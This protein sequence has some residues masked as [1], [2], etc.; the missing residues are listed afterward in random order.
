MVTTSEDNGRDHTFRTSTCQLSCFCLFQSITGVTRACV[1]RHYVPCQNSYAFVNLSEKNI[2]SRDDRRPSFSCSFSPII[3]QS[4]AAAAGTSSTSSDPAYHSRST[5]LLTDFW[6][7]LISQGATKDVWV[8]IRVHGA[9][10]FLR[11]SPGGAMTE[12]HRPS[13]RMM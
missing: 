7:A 1:C 2:P 4:L 3:F 6:D 13:S 10:G 12:Y 9:S 11:L 5:L 8:S